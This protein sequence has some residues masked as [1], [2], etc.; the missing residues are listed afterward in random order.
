MQRQLQALFLG[1]R[2]YRLHEVL[3][4][5]PHLLFG[6]ERAIL[7]EQRHRGGAA[8]RRRHER[9]QQLEIVDI[10]FDDRHVELAGGGAAAGLAVA[11]GGPHRVGHEVQPQHRHAGPRHGADRRLVVLDLLVAP[12]EAHHGLVVEVRRHVFDRLELQPGRFDLVDQRL[13]VRLFPAV[14]AG[15]RRVVH[16][17]SVDADL[18]RKAEPVLGQVV[19][20]P[21]RYPHAHSVY[22]CVISLSGS[23]SPSRRLRPCR[24]P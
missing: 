7:A 21:D 6:D 18:R 4:V 16:L 14:I 8:Q 19:E 23:V 3:V 10:G 15:K 24:P 9:A 2:Q 5:G 22:S 17:Q 1:D 20:L 13:D 11:V 12:I